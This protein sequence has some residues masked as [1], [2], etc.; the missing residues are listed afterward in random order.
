[1]ALGHPP[2]WFSHCVL[3]CLKH[4]LLSYQ[5]YWFYFLA[6]FCLDLVYPQMPAQCRLHLQLFLLRAG[7]CSEQSST[8]AP[9]ESAQVQTCSRNIPCV[10]GLVWFDS[11]RFCSVLLFSSLRHG[12]CFPVYSTT[13]LPGFAD[14]TDRTAFPLLPPLCVLILSVGKHHYLLALHYSVCN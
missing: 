2:P 6:P 5:L 4:H 12:C 9:Y 3:L 8:Y 7:I 10:H 11:V 13:T 1:M 14:N